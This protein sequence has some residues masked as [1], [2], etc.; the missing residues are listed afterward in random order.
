MQVICS[1]YCVTGSEYINLYIK[2]REGRTKKTKRIGTSAF[3]K[4]YINF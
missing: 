3:F 2:K 4:Y 1:Y